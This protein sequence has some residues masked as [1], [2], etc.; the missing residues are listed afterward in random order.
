VS[1]ELAD[2][3]PDLVRDNLAQALFVFHAME[4][5]AGALKEG[6]ARVLKT[7]DLSWVQLESE[8]PDVSAPDIEG[9]PTSNAVNTGLWRTLRP[10]LHEEH[11]HGCTWICSTYCPDSAISTSV[12]G[13]KRLPLID[14]DHC[15]GCMICSTVC[16]NHAI[17][18]IPETAT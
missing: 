12:A 10:V 3:G 18:V 9:G 1:E 11:C 2:L 16:P 14:Y 4:Y 5:A 15:K 13:D 17:E 8:P 6:S 7:T